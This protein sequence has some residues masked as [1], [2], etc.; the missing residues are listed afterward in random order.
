MK[1]KA[2][3]KTDFYVDKKTGI[4]WLV[5]FPSESGME[6][7]FDLNVA[8]EAEKNSKVCFRKIKQ[9]FTIP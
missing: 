1:E 9:K 7:G 5:F 8:R 2:S 6:E 4:L 3:D